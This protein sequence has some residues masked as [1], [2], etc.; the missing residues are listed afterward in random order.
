M[1]QISA[2]KY[3]YVV[4]TGRFLIP[5][6]VFFNPLVTSTLAIFLDSLDGTLFY[7]AGFSWKTYNLVDK[8][9]D[10]WWLFFIVAYIFVA[11]P[12]LFYLALA[13]FI[14]RIVGT[15]LVFLT[16]KESLYLLFPNVIE[17]FFNVILI[18]EI[19][20]ISTNTTTNIFLSLVVALI[21]EYGIHILK[22]PLWAKHVLKT[23][24]D[25]TKSP[26]NR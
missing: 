23:N 4:E 13:L 7:R 22:Y 1:T 17:R 16:N 2:K 24:V 3:L 19:L 10:L 8:I 26:A 20:Q 12:T 14:L 6:L 25:W 9:L 21:F 5:F 15:A 11:F 18:F